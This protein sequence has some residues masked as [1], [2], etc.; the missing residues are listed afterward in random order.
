MFVY[1]VERS[2]RLYSPNGG[3]FLADRGPKLLVVG[4]G[5][6][7]KHAETRLVDG[8]RPRLGPPARQ[9][10]GTCLLLRYDIG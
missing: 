7:S 3:G 6:I 5:L 2:L 1:D 4:G 10:L 9:V 8:W